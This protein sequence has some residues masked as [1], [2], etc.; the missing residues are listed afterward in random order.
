MATKV[1]VSWKAFSDPKRAEGGRKVFPVTSVEV[2]MPEFNN[3]KDLDILNQVYQDTNLYNGIF[4][5]IL[6]EVMPKDRSHTALSINDEV[7]VIRGNGMRLYRCAET[8]WELIQE[9]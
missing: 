7:G 1:R 2:M 5:D 9:N 6:E 4:W 3:W 8:G